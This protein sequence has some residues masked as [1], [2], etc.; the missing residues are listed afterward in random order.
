MKLLVAL[1]VLCALLNV[2]ELAPVDDVDCTKLDEVLDDL[3]A[4]Q[5]RTMTNDKYKVEKSSEGLVKYCD[6][7]KDAVKTLKKY[8]KQCISNLTQQVVSA[9]LR[10]RTQNIESICKPDS[11][12]FKEIV[13]A[14][15]CTVDNADLANG[16]ELKF[17]RDLWALIDADFKDTKEFLHR[18][19]C[20]I[21]EQQTKLVGVAKE[22]CPQYVKSF[23][24]YVES[25]S[26]EAMGLVCP[27]AKSLECNKYEPLK[28]DESAKLKS[29]FYLL[30]IVKAVNKLDQ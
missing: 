11:A 16:I 22:K 7:A 27:E 21:N 18:T 2:V 14:N 4:S 8:N 29:S 10:T 28:T 1:S 13:E 26:S 19:C 5:A 24:E 25:Y 9:I 20:L 12:E 30:P 17:L 6:R 23:T 3:G 15:N